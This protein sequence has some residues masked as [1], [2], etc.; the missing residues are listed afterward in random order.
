MRRLG[1]SIMFGDNIEVRQLNIKA[2]KGGC[3]VF[4]C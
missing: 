1:E 3:V 4:L 2:V